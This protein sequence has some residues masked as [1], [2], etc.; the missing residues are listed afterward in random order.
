MYYYSSPSIALQSISQKNIFF[1]RLVYLLPKLVSIYI[2][3]CIEYIFPWYWQFWSVWVS[4]CSCWSFFAFSFFIESC[5]L[6]VCVC[7]KWVDI[8]RRHDYDFS[9]LNIIKKKSHFF[10]KSNCQIRFYLLAFLRSSVLFVLSRPQ[11]QCEWHWIGSSTGHHAHCKQFIEPILF[12]SNICSRVKHDT[13]LCIEW[14]AKIPYR[15]WKERYFWTIFEEM[16]IRVTISIERKFIEWNEMEWVWWLFK[17]QSLLM[18]TLFSLALYLLL[19]ES[20]IRHAF[21]LLKHRHTNAWNQENSWNRLY[22]G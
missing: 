13:S 16:K 12:R 9:I 22:I 10:S 7:V 4:I 5:E 3:D 17:T 11:T 19:S 8:V 15:E 6:C 2:F 20:Q 1:H 18:K 21:Q 14:S